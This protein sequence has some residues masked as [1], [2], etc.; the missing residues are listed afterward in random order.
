MA[1]APEGQQDVSPWLWLLCL[2]VFLTLWLSI[3]GHLCTLLMI[4]LP[5]A[6][7]STPAGGP[8]T[9]LSISQWCSS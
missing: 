9:G 2:A 4:T 5:P 8:V 7:L 6:A 1:R 3:E